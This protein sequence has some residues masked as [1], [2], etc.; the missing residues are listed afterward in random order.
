MKNKKQVFYILIFGIVGYIFGLFLSY[1]HVGS[2]V[3]TITVPYFDLLVDDGKYFFSTKKDFELLSKL[4][5]PQSQI[6]LQRF[7]IIHGLNVSD[8]IFRDL[9]IS[10]RIDL[11]SGTII[12]SLPFYNFMT[13]DDFKIY[14]D[15]IVFHLNEVSAAKYRKLN[16]RLDFKKI[17]LAKHSPLLKKNTQS[18]LSSIS[19]SE[20]Q[21]LLIQISELENI[22]QNYESN[23]YYVT[24]GA[25]NFFWSSSVLSFKFSLLFILLG[26]LLCFKSLREKCLSFIFDDRKF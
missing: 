26:T 11:N 16:D 8:S 14:V 3:A 21:D 7:N 20:A 6:L 5:S 2:K 1:I 19:I 17:A 22:L 12:I 4:Q 25:T 18:G 9:I 10:A 24:Y 23:K 15:G 13:L